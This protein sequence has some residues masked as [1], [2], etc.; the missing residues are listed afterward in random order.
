MHSHPVINAGVVI[1]GQLTVIDENNQSLELKAGDALV[2][3]V[4]K[5]HYGENKGNTVSELIVFYAGAMQLP[6]TVVKE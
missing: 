6:I 2:E 4:N 3:M 1:K 5:Y